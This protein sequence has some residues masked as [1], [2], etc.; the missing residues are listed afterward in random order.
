MNPNLPGELFVHQSEI[1]GNM[2]AHGQFLRP[3]RMRSVVAQQG[4]ESRMPGG[5]SV[6]KRLDPVSLSH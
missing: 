2:D 6:V 3:D 4:R 1:R 5:F